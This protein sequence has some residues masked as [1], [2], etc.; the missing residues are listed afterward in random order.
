MDE[1]CEPYPP[2]LISKCIL[3]QC[4]YLT[5][6]PPVVQLGTA[7]FECLFPLV[8]SVD[9]YK[10]L[11]HFVIDI[12]K[13]L[14]APQSVVII[15]DIKAGLLRLKPGIVIGTTATK[16]QYEVLRGFKPSA[17]HLSF[18]PISRKVIISLVIF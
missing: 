17:R 11:S 3:E 10:V 7:V 14:R 13:N 18:L 5:A 2:S 6:D 12:R 1:E 9:A 16:V 8:F 4:A 15:E